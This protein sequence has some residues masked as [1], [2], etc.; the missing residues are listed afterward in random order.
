[1]SGGGGSGAKRLLGV[2]VIGWLAGCAGLRDLVPEGP[3]LDEVQRATRL[4]AAASSVPYVGEAVAGPPVP[5]LQAFGVAY[6]LDL[7]LRSRHPSWDMHEIARIDTPSG[8]LWIA[9]DARRGSLAQ[10]IVADVPDIDAWFP[11]VQVERRAG[12]VE[13]DDRSTPGQ[14]DVT[15]RYDNVD[16]VPSEVTWR[17]PEPKGPMA[18]R[19]TSTMGHSRDAVAAVLDLSH[20][21]FARSASITI[22]GERQRLIHLLGLVPFKVALAQ[23]QAGL[24]VG[25]LRWT[26]PTAGDGGAGPVS[27]NDRGVRLDWTQDASDDAVTLTQVDALRTLRHRFVVAGGALEQ[28]E[29]R[30]TQVGRDVDTC[31]LTASPPLPDARRR[32]EGEVR[33]ALVFDVNGQDSHGVADWVAAWRGDA[34]VIDVTPTAPRWLVDRPM[35]VTATRDA[36]GWRVVTS[37]R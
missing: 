13:V 34:L 4:G 5:L 16:G 11:E 30:V 31:R 18:K 9:K 20:R 22:G 35:R 26:P 15:V 2:V 8:P 10:T 6:D 7:V 19:N 17:G 23:V 32:F 24:S 27:V 33:G 14:V 36:E 3:V 1:M 29:A 28:R 12:R 37:R 25:D 21:S